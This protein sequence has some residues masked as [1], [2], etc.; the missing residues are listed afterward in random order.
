MDLKELEELNN[1]QNQLISEMML[2]IKCLEDFLVNKKIV[3][4]QELVEAYIGATA[5]LMEK[6]KEIQN[7]G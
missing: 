3:S 1:K 2:R 6:I 5:K 7:G 4:E